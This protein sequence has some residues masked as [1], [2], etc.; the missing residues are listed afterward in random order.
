MFESKHTVAEDQQ[1]LALARRNLRQQGKQVVRDALRVLAHDTA[2][3][4]TGW[5]EV[6]QQGTVP[7]LG[8]GVVARLGRI[9]ALGVDHVGDG[10]LNRKL[11]VSVG[12]S[13]AERAHLGD[14]NH[15]RE[16]RGIAVHSG[17]AGEDD[18]GDVV[19]DHGAQEA[20]GTVD[21]GMVVIERLLA[22]FP[23]RLIA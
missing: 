2:R 10:V 18:V 11:G 8:L 5:V 22:G 12:V 14:G 17:R 20:D 19:A 9:V 6:A 23:H 21:V 3:V 7:L 13:G 1:L 15:V 16:S 4:G